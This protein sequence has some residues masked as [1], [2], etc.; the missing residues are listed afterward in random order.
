VSHEPIS[1]QLGSTV[2][3]FEREVRKI[4][5]GGVSRFTFVTN[6]ITWAQHAAQTRKIKKVK[7]PEGQK[8]LLKPRFR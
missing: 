7:K 5:L 3:G 4:Y 1:P 8:Q 6:R 2:F